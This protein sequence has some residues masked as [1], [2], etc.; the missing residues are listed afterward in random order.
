MV[1]DV[2]VNQHPTLKVLQGRCGPKRCARRPA[3][4]HKVPGE[5]KDRS[6]SLA[7]AQGELLVRL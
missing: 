1:D 4:G 6:E 3:G 7:A 2:V 5:K